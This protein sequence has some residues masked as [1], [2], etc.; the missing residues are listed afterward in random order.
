MQAAR[1][2]GQGGVDKITIE[3][4]PRPVPKD[5]EV[6]VKVRAAGMNPI[7]WKMRKFSMPGRSMPFPYTAGLDFAGTVEEVGPGGDPSIL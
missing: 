1:I 7:D 3:E 6:L 5:G 2:S 4:I